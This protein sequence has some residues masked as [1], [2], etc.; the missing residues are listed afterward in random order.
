[1]KYIFKTTILVIVALLLPACASDYLDTLPTST[2]G[3][4]TVFETKEN[5]QLAINGMCL[6]LK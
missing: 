6:V 4:A 3:T 5:A 1:M 2:I